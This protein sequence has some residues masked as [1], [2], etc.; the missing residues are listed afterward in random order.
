MSNTSRGWMS[1]A[2][3][4]GLGDTSQRAGAASIATSA[5]SCR[6]ANVPTPLRHAPSRCHGDPHR[7]AWAGGPPPWV[8]QSWAVAD[9]VDI[10]P[11]RLPG[12]HGS[13]RAGSDPASGARLEELDALGNPGLQPRE[14]PGRVMKFVLTRLFGLGRKVVPMCV[15][16]AWPIGT[17]Q[18]AH[19]DRG[20]KELETGYTTSRHVVPM[21]YAAETDDVEREF[22]VLRL[23]EE[24]RAAGC[25]RP[26]ETVDIAASLE[27]LAQIAK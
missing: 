6:N 18:W 16:P 24:P 12:D 5:V 17:F 26:L 19:R 4:D 22:C 3:I 11:S 1:I 14:V 8:V 10:E 7:E 27:R 25:G 2:R 15:G 23:G 9:G 13:S 21:H 20:H